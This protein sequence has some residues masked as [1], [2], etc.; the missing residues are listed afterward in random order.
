[1]SN[2]FPE[3]APYKTG[4]LQ[5]S[6]T[7][8]I[9]YEQVGNPKG[10][11][12]VFL[13]GGPGGNI[14]PFYR[15]FFDPSIFNVLLF[16]QRGAGKSLPFACIEENTTMDLV[17]DIEKLR[18]LSNVEQWIVF[19]GSWGS[20]LALAYATQH[21]KRTMGM[22]LRGVFLGRQAELDWLYGPVGA[23]QIFPEEYALF[24]KDLSSE[25]IPAPYHQYLKWL[26]GPDLSVQLKASQ[27]WNRW[28][29]M[30]SQLIPSPYRPESNDELKKGLAISRIECHYFVNKL[31]L[32][33]EN[34]VFNALPNVKDIPTEIINGRYDIVCPPWTAVQVHKILKNSKLHIV[35]DAGHSTTEPGISSK[36]LQAMDNMAQRFK[37][38]P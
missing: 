25:D 33:D 18:Q 32:S 2:Y 11:P 30:I 12:V 23:A 6:S 34:Q 15:R 37:T 16:D 1:M 36:L 29:N 17:N 7:H 5:V 20:T 10:I 9:Y 27:A 22:V 21:P 8:Q 4:Y 35:P 3:T 38:K 19:G 26:N 24:S 14:S 28:E 31:F 13:H